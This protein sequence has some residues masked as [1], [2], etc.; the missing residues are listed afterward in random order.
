MG[1]VFLHPLIA[2]SKDATQD[3][4]QTTGLTAYILSPTIVVLR[5]AGPAPMLTIKPKTVTT[6]RTRTIPTGPF[7]GGGDAA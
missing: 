5:P 7:N 3:Y 2:S 6:K 1:T 4:E